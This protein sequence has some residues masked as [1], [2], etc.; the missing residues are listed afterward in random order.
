MPEIDK[1]ITSPSYVEDEFE[2]TLRPRL[3][4]E[5][6]GQ[7]KAKENLGILIQAAKQR[8]DPIE[9]IM[10]YGPPGLGKTTLAHVI[11]NEMGRNIRITSGPAI[12][13]AGDLASILTNL[14]EGDILFVDE[15][16]RINRHVEEV[17]YPAMEDFAIDLVVGKGP[18]ARTMRLELPRFTLIGAT[19][20]IGLLSSPL[21][22]RF[23]AVYRL[24]FYGDAELSKIV[25]R[26]SRIIKVSVDKGGVDEIAK[27]SRR[28]PRIAN[29]LL[30][31]VRDYAEVKHSGIVAEDIAKEALN[32][33]DIDDLGLD[34]SDREYLRTVINKFRGGPV[35]LD[36]IAAAMAE[37]KDT[38]ED[39]IEPYLLQ[40]GFISRTKQG[41]VSMPAAYHHLCINTPD[42]ENK[43]L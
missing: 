3:L 23:G 33:L 2:E 39:V 16:H 27:R 7:E 36:T 17:L 41:R 38:I 13:R 12:E 10:L 1:K 43:L 29:R 26:S 4:A 21:R 32:Q 20:R 11:A 25:R 9:H 6:I 19:T 34:Q 42:K 37:D 31:R 18:S 28:T 24:E 8:N 15:I 22:D 5:Y 35:G 30:R 14:E 40:L